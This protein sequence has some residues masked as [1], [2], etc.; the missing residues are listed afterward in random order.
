MKLSRWM[1]VP[2]LAHLLLAVCLWLYI[3]FEFN[4][5]MISGR[6]FGLS[7]ETIALHFPPPAGRLLYATNFPAYTLSNWVQHL[8]QWRTTPALQFTW[9][10]STTRLPMAL[11]N[12][13][14][15]ELTFFLGVCGLWLW[16]GASIDRSAPRYDTH[17]RW[18]RLA[19]MAAVLIVGMILS[20]QCIVGLR[21][22]DSPVR[23]IATFGLI[24]PLVLFMKFFL[25]LRQELG[26]HRRSVAA[27]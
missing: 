8:I 3:P 12:F 14:L 13:G 16:V 22:A 17:P 10:D 18:N 9:E 26:S 24:W 2:P 25:S 11:Y 20:W 23:T 19:E 7:A 1:L 5:Q 27:L 6:S 15:R 4:R 21:S